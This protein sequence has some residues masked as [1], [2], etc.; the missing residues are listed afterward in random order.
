[1]EFLHVGQAGLK[2]PLR[3]SLCC[4]GEVQWRDLGSLQPSIPWFKQLSC[5]SL[6]NIWDYRQALP[7]PAN[8]CIVETGFHHIGHDDRVLLLLPR[9]ES[10]GAISAHC[11]LRLSG[12]SNSPA[13]AILSSWDHRHAL[14]CLANFCIISRDGVSLCSPGWSLTPDLRNRVSLCCSADF[15]LLGSSNLPNLAS[16]HPQHCQNLSQPYVPFKST[17]QAQV[18]ETTGPSIIQGLIILPKLV[19]N[20][21]FQVILP[22]LPSKTLIIGA[23]HH[24]Q[25]VQLF[26]TSFGSGPLDNLSLA[27]SSRLECSDM[28]STHCNLRLLGSSNSHASVSQVAVITEMHHHTRLIFVFL[29]ETV[30][31]NVGQAGFEFLASKTRFHHI[32]QAGLELLTS[33]YISIWTNH[34]CL[35]VLRRS[36]ALLPRLECNGVISAHCNLCLQVQEILLP[37]PLEQSFTLVTQTVGSRLTTTSASRDQRLGFSMLVWLVSNFKP[38]VIHPPWRP[39]VLGLQSLAL[40]PKLEGNGVISAHCNLCLPEI[41]SCYVAPASP[42]LL[43]SSKAILPPRSPQALELLMRFH[44]VGQAGLELLTSGDPP[45]SASQSARITGVS[46]CARPFF[47]FLKQS[48]IL[49]PRLECSGVILAHC[50]LCRPGYPAASSLCLWILTTLTIQQCQDSTKVSSK[51]YWPCAKGRKCEPGVTL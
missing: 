26:L 18:A 15:K 32:G 37:Q 43:A 29:V 45:T 3:V 50:N 30:F 35:F 44:H 28:I 33:G 27:L 7:R 48:L 20:S 34:I 21:W 23:S 4:Q 31:R 22:S 42:E 13:S 38:Q 19:L 25:P 39:K 36:L 17:S 1:M 11:N 8:F 51:G 6:P 2:L 5:L 40:L 41:K 9:L 12:S 10:N 24:T 46:H 49:S 47:V 16:H 14:P